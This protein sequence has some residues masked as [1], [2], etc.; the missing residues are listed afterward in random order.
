MDEMILINT[1]KLQ[2][3]LEESIRKVLKE[4]EPISNE[5]PPMNITEASR[6]LKTS[7]STLY[8]YTSQRFIPHHKPG[9][10]LYFFRDELDQWLAEHK[11]LTVNEIEAGDVIFKN[12]K[13]GKTN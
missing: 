2:T 6:Y 10:Q 3:L 11:K 9:K 13:S 12:K 5:H 7:V 4:K 1:V 8:R